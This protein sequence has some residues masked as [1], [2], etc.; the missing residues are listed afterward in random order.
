MNESNQNIAR[1]EMSGTM[2]QFNRFGMGEFTAQKSCGGEI[3]WNLG[4]FIVSDKSENNIFE[5]FLLK[6]CKRNGLI[7]SRFSKNIQR[8]Q[9]TLKSLPSK[10]LF[11]YS[12][13]QTC[14]F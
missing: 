2:Q 11:Q 6:K 10:V 14:V 4:Y 9:Q 7:N 3:G 8:I 5:R 13:I 1:M 12:W